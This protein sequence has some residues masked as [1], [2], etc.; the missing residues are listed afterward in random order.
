MHATIAVSDSD[1]IV[2]RRGS[3]KISEN[4]EHPFGHTRGLA[5]VLDIELINEIVTMNV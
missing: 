4:V 1:F 3:V 5:H 2:T